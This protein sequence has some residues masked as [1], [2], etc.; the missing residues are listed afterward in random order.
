LIYT[1]YF[2]FVKNI[3]TEYLVAVAGGVPDGFTGARYRALAPKYD[4]WREWHDKNLSNE[5]YTQKYY[6]TV[7]SKL[8]PVDVLRD[9]DGKIILCW[10]KPGVFCHRNLIAEWLI[11]NTGANVC[12]LSMMDKQGFMK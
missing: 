8:N 6:E 11:K 7:L 3:P 1:S 2:A 5:W 10:E 12:E 4:W 9:L